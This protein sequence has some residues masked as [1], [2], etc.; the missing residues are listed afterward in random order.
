MFI[1][2][3]A[4][5]YGIVEMIKIFLKEKAKDFIPL[6]ALI[7]GTITSILCAIVDAELLPTS[8]FLETTI[9]G[10]MCGLSSTGTH[11]ILKHLQRY[12]TSKV[13][14]PSNIFQNLK[15]IILGTKKATKQEAETLNNSINQ[16]QNNELTEISQTLQEKPP[17]NI[18]ISNTA[19]TNTNI[20][21]LNNFLETTKT[22]IEL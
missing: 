20:N 17:T 21:N 3:I 2:F 8:N 11:Q 9:Y 18:Q 10:S 4:I 14:P 16:S 1:I 6:Y 19:R 22:N 5:T 15:N 7:I 13:T 12:F